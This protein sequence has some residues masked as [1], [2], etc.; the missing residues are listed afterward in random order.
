LDY[1]FCWSF[2]LC[3]WPMSLV[4]FTH[5]NRFRSLRLAG[6]GVECEWRWRV[7]MGRAKYAVFCFEISAQSHFFISIVQWQC[8]FWDSQALERPLQQL[9]LSHAVYGCGSQ[10]VYHSSRQRVNNVMWIFFLKVHV[11]ESFFCFYPEKN[12]LSKLIQMNLCQHL[13]QYISEVWGFLQC[14]H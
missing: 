11:P 9:K 8:C 12:V 6:A 2:F 10:V 7:S 5:K 1:W 4:S 3:C 13:W 14:A